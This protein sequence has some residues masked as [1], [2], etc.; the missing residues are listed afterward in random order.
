MSSILKETELNNMQRDSLNMIIGSGELLC[1]VVD[2]V[3]GEFDMYT[4][5]S[6]FLFL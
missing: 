5:S 4:S 3:L 6:T 1:T 2:D